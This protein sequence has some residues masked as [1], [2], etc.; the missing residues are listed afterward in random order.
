MERFDA[1][2][3]S[4]AKRFAVSNSMISF[5]FL[6]CMASSAFFPRKREMKPRSISYE[7]LNTMRYCKLTQMYESYFASATYNEMWTNTKLMTHASV[8]ARFDEPV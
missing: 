4:I 3:D 1:M 7:M 6:S 8:T 5:T 2:S